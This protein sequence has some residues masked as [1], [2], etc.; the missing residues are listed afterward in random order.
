MLRRRVITTEIRPGPATAKLLGGV[1]GGGG[2]GG[3]GGLILNLLVSNLTIN[4][5]TVSAKHPSEYS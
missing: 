1:G 4:P 3:G 2:G 5:D